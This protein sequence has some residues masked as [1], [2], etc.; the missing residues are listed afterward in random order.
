MYGGDVS[1]SAGLEI[2]TA[3]VSS[4]STRVSPLTAM[5]ITP[6]RR[7]RRSRAV[8]PGSP[9]EAKSL[10]SSVGEMATTA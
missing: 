10:P 2:V 8:P 7:P 3:K 4:D 6:S 1:V 5:V 9:A